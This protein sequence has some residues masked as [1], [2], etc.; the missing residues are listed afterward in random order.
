[1]TQRR[2]CPRC[3]EREMERMGAGWYG[4]IWQCLGCGWETE[5]EDEEAWLAR[6][7]PHRL[8]PSR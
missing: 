6:E 4:W 1:M 3:G 2:E 8:D 5:E 7:H